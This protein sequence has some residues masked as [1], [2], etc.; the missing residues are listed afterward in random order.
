MNVIEQDALNLLQ[1]VFGYQQ[2]R[3]HQLDIIA[4]VVAGGDA[5]VLMPTGGGKSL[6]YQIPA[7]MRKGV[8]IVVSPLISLMKDQVD[9]LCANGVRAACYN[10]SLSANEANQV[11]ARLHADELD[12]LYVA[13]ERLLSESFLERLASLEIALFAIDEAHCVSQWGHDFRPEYIQLGKLQHF[14]PSVPRIALTATAEKQTRLDILQRLHLER[15]LQIVAGFDRPNIR[16]TV[17][18]KQRPYEQLKQFLSGRRDEAGIVYALSRKRVE[19]IS[20]RLQ[21]DGCRAAAYHAGLSA[22]DRR[23]TQDAFLRDDL[24]IVVATVAFGMGID[25]PNVRFVVHYDLPKNVESYYQETG[26]AGRDG[27][28]AEALLLFGYG[29]IAVVRGLIEKSDNQDQTR[30]ELQKLNAMVSFAEAGSCRRRALLG[31]FGEPMASD[32]GNC[33]ICLDPP[34]TYAATEDARKALSCVY[35]VGQ[36]FGIGHVIDVLRGAKTERIFSLR[37]E[38]LSTWGI[39]KEQ[40]QEH[41]SHLL[42]QLIHLGYLEQD[43]GNYSVLKLTESA[44]PLLRGEI[45]LQ[46]SRPRVKAERKKKPAR[47]IV[48]LEYDEQLFQLLRARRKKIA[49]RDGVP[50]YVVF[51]DASLA[52]MAASLPTSDSDLLGI[53]G[54]GQTKLE[55]YGSEFITEII[56]YMSR[57]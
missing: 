11:L 35:R 55:R 48:G 23:R 45:E 51:G 42:R 46:L 16:Y 3:E 12:L 26:R 17:M 19:E 8:G 43:I 14:F 25:K 39:G 44:R 22:D 13:P 53:N 34:E 47:K 29:D 1:K 7:L 6:C 9:A 30:I 5:F 41:W 40:G 54:V 18:D 4:Q 24:Q 57:S 50:P 37:H 21:E 36:R 15:P 52:E 28:P 49:D 31:Y 10:S 2:F 27:L 20:A 56:G 38:Q 32:C 33:D